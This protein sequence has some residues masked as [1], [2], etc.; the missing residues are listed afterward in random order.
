MNKYNV[1]CGSEEFIIR[2]STLQ[3]NEFGLTFRDEDGKI[4]AVFPPGANAYNI[5]YFEEKE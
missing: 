5:A 4:V 2:A 1:Y 3:T